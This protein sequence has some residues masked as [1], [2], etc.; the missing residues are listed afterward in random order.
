MKLISNNQE[1]EDKVISNK[2]AIIILTNNRKSFKFVFE[3]SV[4]WNVYFCEKEFTVSC[5]ELYIYI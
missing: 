5:C 1:Q 2:V 3:E 4:K